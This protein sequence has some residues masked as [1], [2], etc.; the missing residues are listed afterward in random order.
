[1]SVT[2]EQLLKLPSLRLAKPVAGLG[3][4]QRIVSSISV[5]EGG[6]P[7]D[8][9]E[10]VFN[11]DEFFGG[12]IVITGFIAL[13]NDVELQCQVVERLAEMGEVGL[14]IYYVGQF[15]P[16]IDQRLIDLANE[17]DFVLIQMPKGLLRYSEAITDVMDAILRE[18]RNVDNLL[19]E[20]LYEI[21][22]MPQHMRTIARLLNMLSNRVSASLVLQDAQ[23][24]TINMSAW[25]RNFLEDMRTEFEK[26][27]HLPTAELMSV[28]IGT[29]TKIYPY[30][31]ETSSG[32]KRL[33]IVKEGGSIPEDILAQ[34]V[35][36]LRL[37]MNIW[38]DQQKVMAAKEVVS[39]I[40][41]DEPLKMRRLADIF[42]IDVASMND[43]VIISGD[44]PKDHAMLS[45]HAGEIIELFTTSATAV[46]ADIFDGDLILLPTN[47][48]RQGDFLDSVDGV[49]QLC[50]EKGFQIDIARYANLC[51]TKDVRSVYLSHKNHLSSAKIIFPHNQY[52][53][54]E[55]ILF[56][57][58][59]EGIID[60]GEEKIQ[61]HLAVIAP[62]QTGNEGGDYLKTLEVFLLDTPCN[63]AQTAKMMFVHTN[64]IKYRMAQLT[65]ILGYKPDLMPQT[66][67]LYKAVAIKRLLVGL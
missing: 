3:G 42:H 41:Q 66:M 39:A 19:P 15:L 64:T 53:N 20:M 11:N 24:H 54:L 52:F 65:K 57:N 37:A 9:V 34:C 2:V 1:M 12:E 58:E 45:T 49:F 44:S 31:F 67:R 25:P 55:H 32:K 13:K 23:F 10:D 51:T 62:L 61:S 50:D 4:L 33:S 26:V 18:R 7:A 17:L 40:L 29:N 21:S 63:I 43:L 48:H 35:E 60:G 36:T 47:L 8:L 27:G 14:I 22:R 6:Q 28:S 16:R 59:C 30:E 56:A 38:G 5:Y 46:V